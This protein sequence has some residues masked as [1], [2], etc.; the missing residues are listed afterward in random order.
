MIEDNN[1]QRKREMGQEG[2][3]VLS[4]VMTYTQVEK[5]L[6]LHLRFLEIL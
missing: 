6:G 4:M 3:K 2:D 5:I 1:R